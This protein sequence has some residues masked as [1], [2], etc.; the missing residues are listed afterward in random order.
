MVLNV[1]LYQWLKQHKVCGQGCV[2]ETIG[3]YEC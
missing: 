3:M 2:E 1:L